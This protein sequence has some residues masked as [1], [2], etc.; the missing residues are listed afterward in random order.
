MIVSEMAIFR[1]V[2]ATNLQVPFRRD[3]E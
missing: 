1:Q 3:V 2:L